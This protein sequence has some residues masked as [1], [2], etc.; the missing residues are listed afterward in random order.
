MTTTTTA[1]NHHETTV[2]P[3]IIVEQ[4]SS[5]N[6]SKRKPLHHFLDTQQNDHH[7]SKKPN[8]SQLYSQ[9][10]NIHISSPETLRRAFSAP[11]SPPMQPFSNPLTP[12]N[13]T[14]KSQT[15]LPRCASDPTPVLGFP[16]SSPESKIGNS[17][18][19]W[20]VKA[21]TAPLPPRQE[22][23]KKMREIIGV[24]SR[25]LRRIAQDDQ[26]KEQEQEGSQDTRVVQIPKGEN[27]GEKC[28]PETEEEAVSVEKIGECLVLQFKCNC[29]KTY[30]I[31]LYGDV[32]YY[33]LM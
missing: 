15:V 16:V 24:T 27:V 5:C 8:L 11:T 28:D 21:N 31:L 6:S 22:K 7:L 19:N 32:C 18:G 17:S 1:N 14:N 13:N 33:K 29:S 20:T 10:T 9:F 30:Q 2:P 12:E 25:W 4:C 3:T 23:V 26:E